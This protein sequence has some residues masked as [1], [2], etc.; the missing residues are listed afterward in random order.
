MMLMRIAPPF[1][2]RWCAPIHSRLNTMPYT[3]L[4]PCHASRV[5]SQ[6]DPGSALMR[7]GEVSVA[8]AAA[9]K[10]LQNDHGK[11]CFDYLGE[12]DDEGREW[13]ETHAKDVAKLLSEQEP[14]EAKR[15][16]INAIVLNY[17]SLRGLSE[18]QEIARMIAQLTPEQA[19]AQ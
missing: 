4:M 3:F 6:V 13:L 11:K 10:L 17:L 8:H 14:D 2:D 12:D 7:F 16:A 5:R 9:K 15:P 1:S 19:H 18:L